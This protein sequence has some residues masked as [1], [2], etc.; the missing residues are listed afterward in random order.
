V[1]PVIRQADRL[2]LAELS[3]QGKALGDKARAGKLT[4][5]EMTGGTFTISNMGMLNVE[6]FSAIINTGESGI[7][8]VAS[9]LKQAVVRED[10]IV[11]RQIMKMTLSADHRIVDGALAAQFINSIKAKLEDSELWKRL[12]S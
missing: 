4:P 6:N 9:T 2:S 10:K 1:V 7:L 8:A 3:A 5:D 11:I 12:T